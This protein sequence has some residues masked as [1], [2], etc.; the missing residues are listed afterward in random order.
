M[1]A[2][3]MFSVASFLAAVVGLAAT[4]LPLLQAL[5]CVASIAAAVVSIRLAKKRD[6]RRR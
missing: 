4:A 1:N 6:E 5:A 3:H 2:H